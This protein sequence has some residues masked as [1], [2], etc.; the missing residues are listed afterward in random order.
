MQ[1]SYAI[2]IDIGG[3]STKI[4]RVSP[5][6]EVLEISTLPTD[7][8]RGVDA[9]IQSVV[10]ETQ[11]L[12]ESAPRG[13]QVEGIG[14]AVAGFIDPA[15][16][17][18]TFNPNLPWL[19]DFPL[20]QAFEKHFGLPTAVE[21]D[22]NAA[23]LSEYFFGVGAGC[24]RFFVLS[25][26]TGVGG[27]MLVDG[28]LLRISNE[29]LGDVGHVIVDP[30]GRVCASG[31]KGCAEA[32]IS[33]PGL[34]HLAQELAGSYPHSDLQTRLHSRHLPDM[35]QVIG[36]AREGDPLALAVLRQA[37]RWLGIALATI[38]PVFAP[39]RIAIA[40]GVSEAGELLLDPTGQTYRSICGSEYSRH[41]EIKTAKLGW[42]A[43]VVGAS[44]PFLLLG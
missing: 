27:G 34:E 16:T 44:C 6:G 5:Q 21:I 8:S 37:G 28:K 20:Y 31:C 15:H 2:G 1:S 41:V 18:M 29:C 17:R 12:I 4:A 40:G 19:Q 11:K 13:A 22:S 24:S 25:I 14:L 23:A 32:V 9:F 39:D 42:Q 10:G 43:V 35:R 7:G 33:A 3:T 36:A 30:G 38:T 26:G